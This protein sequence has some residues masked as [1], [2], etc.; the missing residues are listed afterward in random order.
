MKSDL[1][2][3]N[4]TLLVQIPVCYYSRY[5]GE[6]TTYSELGCNWVNFAGVAHFC[7]G[8]RCSQTDQN[9]QTQM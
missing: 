6:G 7:F 2:G 5:L 8:L 3:G 4:I 1:A 9:P